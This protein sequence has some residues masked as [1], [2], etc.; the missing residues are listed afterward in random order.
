MNNVAYVQSGEQHV[1][2]IG[3][4]VEVVTNALTFSSTAHPVSIILKLATMGTNLQ[5]TACIDLTSSIQSL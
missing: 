1:T 5:N 3:L 2:L 4:A